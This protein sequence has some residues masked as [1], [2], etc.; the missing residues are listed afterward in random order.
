MKYLPLLL[1]LLGCTPRTTTQVAGKVLRLECCHHSYILFEGG[2][3]EEI[4]GYYA[5]PG[6][7]ILCTVSRNGDKIYYFT[8]R[9]CLVL[10]P[11]APVEPEFGTEMRT[12]IEKPI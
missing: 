1:L 12:L 11:V 7:D 9:D 5:E 6:M 2:H 4:R 3:I 10:P 8:L